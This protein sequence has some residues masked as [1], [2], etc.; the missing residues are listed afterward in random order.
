MKNSS[1][2]VLPG[3]ITWPLEIAEA[4]IRASFVHPVSI[5]RGE[6]FLSFTLGEIDPSAEADALEA[7][8]WWMP[9]LFRL[10]VS[11]AYYDDF[12]IKRSKRLDG[13]LRTI[14]KYV[15]PVVQEEYR[16]GG[17]LLL[18]Q[19]DPTYPTY[20]VQIDCDPLEPVELALEIK[21]TLLRSVFALTLARP[22][23]ELGLNQGGIFPAQGKALIEDQYLWWRQSLR[24]G[25]ESFAPE[26]GRYH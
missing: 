6:N 19:D 22:L 4:A 17:R 1:P 9:R 18:A 16:G 21:A 2:L 26:N 15:E 14:K 12:Y 23:F 5:E 11:I 13:L 3:H 7:Y 24:S 25:P 8:I 10:D 20:E